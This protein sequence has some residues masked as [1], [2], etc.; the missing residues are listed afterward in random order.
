VRT[1]NGPFDLALRCLGDGRLHLRL[2]QKGHTLGFRLRY[3][4]RTIEVQLEDEFPTPSQQARWRERAREIL[5]ER[6]VQFPVGPIDRRMSATGDAEPFSRAGV[7]VRFESTAPLGENRHYCLG[8]PIPVRRCPPP[9][10]YL[11]SEPGFSSESLELRYGSIFG[12]HRLLYAVAYDH[13]GPWPNGR[14]VTAIRSP[15]TST[16]TTEEPPA[17]VRCYIAFARRYVGVDDECRAAPGPEVFEA[18]PGEA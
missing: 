7:G 10:V 18:L 13:G 2:F 6:G 8:W 11:T 4:A 14:Q 5:I 16:H 1:G 9:N 12:G 17:D 15:V 3:L